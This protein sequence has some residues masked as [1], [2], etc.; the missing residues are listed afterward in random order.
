MRSTSIVGFTLCVAVISGCGVATISQS[1][2]DETAAVNLAK[3]RSR[4]ATQLAEKP[5]LITFAE[6]KK[7]YSVSAP[8]YSEAD[9]LYVVRL[10]GS[11][12][13]NG[14]VGAGANASANS[15]T[16]NTVTAFVAKKDG[17]VISLLAE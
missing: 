9:Q 11:Y 1:G 16:Y 5:S 14:A 12:T 7:R 15:T 4:G 8:A 6:A 17:R 2:I 10:T 13:D 3:E